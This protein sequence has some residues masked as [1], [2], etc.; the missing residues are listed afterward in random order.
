MHTFKLGQTG[1]Q[2]SI[3]KEVDKLMKYL[4]KQ[5]GNGFNPSTL[6]QLCVSNIISAFVVGHQFEYD[7][8]R[9]IKMIE[10][11]KASLQIL[12]YNTVAMFFPRLSK[13]PFIGLSTFYDYYD[14]FRAQL[15]EEVTRHKLNLDKNNPKDFIDYY[16]IEMEK[17]DAEE[18]GFTD[19][20][21]DIALTDMFI[22]GTETSASTICWCMLM[23]VLHPDIQIKVQQELDTVIPNEQEFVTLNDQNRCVYVQA[24]IYETLRYSSIGPFT[25]RAA[26]EDT[27]FRGYRIPKGTFYLGDIMG[28]M[29]SPKLWNKPKEFIPERFLSK[30]EPATLIKQEFLLPFSTGK[31]YICKNIARSSFF[32]V[33]SACVNGPY[34]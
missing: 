12:S 2:E 34:A 22:A 28:T 27:V 6:M 7:D 1:G 18:N 13:L 4:R 31:P 15:G 17:S 10:T 20:C 16:L 32:S 30:G 11:M 24:V 25:M 29:H 23:L 8:E 14:S 9:H 19:V 5:N 21:L 33:S 26:T 3:V